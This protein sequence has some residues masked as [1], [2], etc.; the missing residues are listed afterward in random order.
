MPTPKK[1]EDYEIITERL[2]SENIEDKK[3]Y[4]VSSKILKEFPDFIWGSLLSDNVSIIKKIFGK[5]EPLKDL[6]EVNATSTASESDEYFKYI[7]SKKGGHPLIITGTIDR[8][9]T[10][11][12]IKE[13]SSKGKKLKKPLMEKTNHY[14]LNLPFCF[15]NQPRIISYLIQVYLI[16][17]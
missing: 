4:K 14:V 3:V 10:T 7:S 8:Y 1:K 12:G 9:S 17:S 5:H 6:A 16:K 11:Y 13:F 2:F 15:Y